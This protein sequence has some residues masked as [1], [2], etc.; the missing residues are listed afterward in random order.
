MSRLIQRRRML[1]LLGGS[2]VGAGAYAGLGLAG[3]WQEQAIQRS[4]CD[5]GRLY[6]LHQELFGKWILLSPQKLGGGTHAVDLATN[7]TLAWISFW[8]YGDTCPISHHVAAYPA[9]DPYAPE[10]VQATVLHALGVDPSGVVRDAFGRDVPLST[11]KVRKA[12]FGFD[13]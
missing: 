8:N 9:D 7:R 12:L 4:R 10:D 11:G 1:Q 13:G 5:R 2:L 6:D 3:M